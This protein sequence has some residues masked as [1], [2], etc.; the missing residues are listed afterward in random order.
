MHPI[1]ETNI[2]RKRKATS[3]TPYMMDPAIFLFKIFFTKYR[4]I[5]YKEKSPSGFEKNVRIIFLNM[6]LDSTYTPTHGERHI[7]TPNKI[8]TMGKKHIP[9]AVPIPMVHIPLKTIR[10]RDDN[11]LML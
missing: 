10:R 2:V 5:R 9:N 8:G 7:T 11:G 4:L 1:V 6:R 3:T